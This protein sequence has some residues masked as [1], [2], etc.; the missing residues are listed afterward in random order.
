MANK[1][2]LEGVRCP[3][4]GQEDRF[5]INAEITVSVTDD[6]T[7]DMDGNYG[8]SENSACF[9]PDCEFNEILS[10]FTIGSLDYETKKEEFSHVKES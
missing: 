7:E 1:N 4:C 5:H 2:C 8:W 3:K 9:C 10:F 6:G